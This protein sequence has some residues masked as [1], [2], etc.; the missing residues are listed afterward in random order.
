[1]QGLIDV[2]K[3]DNNKIYQ[4]FIKLSKY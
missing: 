2:K 3:K 1:M 4:T